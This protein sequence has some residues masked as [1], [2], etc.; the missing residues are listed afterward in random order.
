MV[1]LTEL[2][3]YTDDLLEIQ[4][5]ADYCP[6]GLQIEGRVQVNK[7]VT[8]VSA[9][10]ALIDAAIVA[11]ADA[12]LVHHGYF[13]K[14]DDARIIGMK[15]QRIK[16]LLQADISLL[17]YH[18]PLDA[19][20]LYGNNAQL[21]ERL[22]LSVEG[23]FGSDNGAGPGI[24]MY[25]HLNTPMSG[26]AFSGHIAK[27]LG[28]TP[29]HIPSDVQTIH[30]LAWCTGAAQGYIEQAVDLG[31][32]AFLSGEASEQTV[33]VARECGIHFYAAGHHATERYGVQALGTHLGQHFDLDQHFIDIDNPV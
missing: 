9:S 1:Q 2:V 29:L 24:G 30:T 10:L 12:L 28:R 14:G 23:R 25:G 15:K 31:V 17:G 8:G 27:V 7:L 19:H 5:F 6:N 33:H 22:E 21:G 18:L 3:A 26:P 13:W 20:P 11:G 16:R 4:T 32:D